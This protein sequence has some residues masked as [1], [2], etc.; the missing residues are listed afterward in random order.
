MEHQISYKHRLK[1]FHLCQG[2]SLVFKAT[3]SLTLMIR[4]KSVTCSILIF[5]ETTREPRSQGNQ[6]K[7]YSK[8]KKKVFREKEN[9]QTVSPLGE[10][11]KKDGDD[12]SV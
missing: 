3:M 7:L 10:H 8:D 9:T 6:A 2:Q 5:L 1:S 11:R 4:K 12:V